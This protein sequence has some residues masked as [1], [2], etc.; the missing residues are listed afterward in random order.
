MKLLPNI[1]LPA[2]L[3]PVSAAASSGAGMTG[4]DS[5]LAPSLPLPFSPSDLL[6]RYGPALAFSPTAHHPSSPFFDFKTLLPNTLGE[7]SISL[8]SVGNIERF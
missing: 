7:K 3:P 5:R 4:I 2:Q 6:W 1:T 8:N